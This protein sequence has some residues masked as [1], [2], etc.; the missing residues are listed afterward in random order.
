MW[1]L[2]VDL[3]NPT[4]PEDHPCFNPKLVSSSDPTW[5][6]CWLK[7]CESPAETGFLT[8]VMQAYGLSP[9]NGKLVGNGLSFDLQVKMPP[10]R[11]DF[12][13]NDR[14][15]VEIDGA[16]YHSSPEEVARDAERD[17]ILRSRGYEILR[18]PAK[19]VFASPD[20]AIKRLRTVLVALS[21]QRDLTAGQVSVAD[22]HKV[23]LEEVKS[24]L[25]NFLCSGSRALEEFNAKST[26]FLEEER[27]KSRAKEFI[28]TDNF[29]SDL[30]R[31]IMLAA[32]EKERERADELA[33]KLAEDPVLSRFYL[34]A[35]TRIRV[36]PLGTVGDVRLREEA[37][38]N[39]AIRMRS[40]ES[41]LEKDPELR[42]AFDASRKGVLD[43]ARKASGSPPPPGKIVSRVT[44]VKAPTKSA[45]QAATQLFGTVTTQ[46]KRRNGDEE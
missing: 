43:A 2:I 15:V 29:S 16:A 35:L 21:L 42:A 17:E 32:G 39:A 41:K 18:I 5:T 14:L 25:V 33:A 24:G 44:D 13:A 12:L 36:A 1:S 8:A 30:E 46:K 6:E 20:E 3:R 34:E 40:L 45:I 26:R 37:A 23:G 22:G 38:M 31:T 19:V 11:V 27:I 4:R 7:L 28:K 10:Y 9:Q